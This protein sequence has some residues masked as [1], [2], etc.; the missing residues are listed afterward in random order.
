MHSGFLQ[1]NFS[2]HASKVMFP[3]IAMERP[4]IRY[5]FITVLVSSINPLLLTHLSFNFIRINDNKIQASCINGRI[6]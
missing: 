2:K 3:S 1:A 6:S 5:I 4:D